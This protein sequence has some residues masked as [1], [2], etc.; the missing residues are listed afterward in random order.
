MLLTVKGVRVAQLSYTFGFNGLRRPAGKP[1]IANL[2]DAEVILTEA[3]R[4]R[5]AGAAIVVVSLHWGTEYDH[6]ATPVQV[7]L[8]RRLLASPDVDLILGHHAHVV[9]PFEEING[10]WVAYGMGNEIAYQSTKEPARH[11]GVMPRFTFTE[12]APGRWKVTTVEAFGTWIA[13]S[14][15]VRIVDLAA[16]IADARTPDARRSAYLATLRRIE[17]YVESRGA[18]VTVPGLS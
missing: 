5:T 18:V 4:A 15:Q 17:G 2:I 1:W 8:A 11:E 9:Q 10:K 7:S 12:F 14:P 13:V 3:R 16:V 6:R